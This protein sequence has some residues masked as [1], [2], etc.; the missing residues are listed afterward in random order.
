M[1]QQE[2]HCEALMDDC[3][4]YKE[5]HP[6]KRGRGIVDK[7]TKHSTTYKRKQVQALNITA[8]TCDWTTRQSKCTLDN[9]IIKATS[10]RSNQLRHNCTCPTHLCDLSTKTAADG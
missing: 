2:D 3:G 6:R 4:T 1:S 10:N 7:P 5:A 8:T 9:T